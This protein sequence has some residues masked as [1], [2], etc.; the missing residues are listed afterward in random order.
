MKE[1][2]QW[3]NETK[4]NVRIGLLKNKF[5]TTN[6]ND[7]SYPKFI[8]VLEIWSNGSKIKQLTR[9]LKI[10]QQKYEEKLVNFFSDV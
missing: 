5:S 7:E 9:Q 6:V 4:N 8:F 1:T 10:K 3:S 2:Q